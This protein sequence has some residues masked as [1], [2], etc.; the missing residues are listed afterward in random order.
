[1]KRSKQLY[2]MIEL[3]IGFLNR[4][5]ERGRWSLDHDLT[6]HAQQVGRC[7]T[8]EYDSFAEDAA[9]SSDVLVHPITGPIV[10]GGQ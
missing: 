5:T 2:E 4:R 1:M 7:S 9:R 8:A 6:G 10:P 3:M